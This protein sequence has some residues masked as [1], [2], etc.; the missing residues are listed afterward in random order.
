MYLYRVV[1][2]SGVD[3]PAVLYR[4]QVQ[5]SVWPETADEREL[6][7][8]YAR[9][10]PRLA[11]RLSRSPGLAAVMIHRHNQGTTSQLLSWNP[12]QYYS[13]VVRDVIMN[14]TFSACSALSMHE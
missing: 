2:F 10:F 8:K 3:Q 5:V 12:L 1:E 6:S 4:R 11:R 13:A 9:I 7:L 14:S